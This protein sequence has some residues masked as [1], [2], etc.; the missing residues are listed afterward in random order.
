M[1]VYNAIKYNHDFAGAAGNL[2]PLST[3]TSD[4]SDA[5]A[6]FTGLLTA[7]FKEYLFLCNNIHPETEDAKFS[8]QVN[9]VGGADFN[10]TATN[11]TWQAY[12]SETA[13]QNALQYTNDDQ[14]NGTAFCALA[15]SVG[16]SNDACTSGYLKIYSPSSTVFVKNFVSQFSHDVEASSVFCMNSFSSG[17]FNT[18]SAIDDVQFKF[19]SGEIQAGTIQAFGVSG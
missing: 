12:V 19:S 17:Y 3:F 2:V 7:D 8:F 13:S 16:D 15:E 10:E 5:T 18:T 14:G 4:G 9:A 11:S 6:T 1:A